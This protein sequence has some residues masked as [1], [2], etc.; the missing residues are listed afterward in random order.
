[1]RRL[2]KVSFAVACKII[3]CNIKRWAKAHRASTKRLQGLVSLVYY[4]IALGLSDRGS[5]FF[6]GRI[7]VVGAG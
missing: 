2:A 4:R 3:A 1:M 7:V 5:L 6:K